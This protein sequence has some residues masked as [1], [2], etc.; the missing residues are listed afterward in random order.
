M[1]VIWNGYI[2]G[3]VTVLIE[4]YASVETDMQEFISYAKYSTVDYRN[5]HYHSEE[6]ILQVS[7]QP[8]SWFVR[9][10]VVSGT[11]E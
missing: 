11:E 2:D 8:D 6:E 7:Y 3:I 9:V 4:D 10:D 1:Y 5:K